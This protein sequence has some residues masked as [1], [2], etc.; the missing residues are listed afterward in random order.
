MRLI[1]PRNTFAAAVFT[2]L[3]IGST[4]ASAGPVF[5]FDNPPQVAPDT[6]TDDGLTATFGSPAGVGGFTVAPSQFRAPFSGNALYNNGVTPNTSAPL[7]A[8]FSRGVYGVSM[9]FGT[10]NPGLTPASKITLTA[11]SG[12]LN[13]A[14]VG[15]VSATGTRQQVVNS[16][17]GM[18]PNVEMIF[19]PQGIISFTSTTPFDA[20]ELSAGPGV[21]FAIDNITVVIP[22]PAS[23]T[24]AGVALAGLSI[25]QWRRRIAR[26][27]S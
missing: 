8:S 15:T 4:R 24:L 13:G 14:L 22:E 9:D 23:L 18:S 10:L 2:L 6:Y 27:R 21:N 11:F 25:S 20:I 19:E 26:A 17:S 3:A 7:T 1:S 16:G 12:G 5:T